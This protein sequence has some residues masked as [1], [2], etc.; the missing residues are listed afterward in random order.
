[1]VFT[2]MKTFVL[3]EGGNFRNSWKKTMQLIYTVVTYVLKYVQHGIELDVDSFDG[4]VMD[5]PER[6]SKFN[7][8]FAI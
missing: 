8:Y 5:I 4:Y 7:V 2:D 3:A 6:Y 1:M